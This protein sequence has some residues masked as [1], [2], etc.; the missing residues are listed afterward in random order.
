MVN[1]RI[2]F[3]QTDLANETQMSTQLVPSSC[4]RSG[5][6][7]G[8]RYADYGYPHASSGMICA[9]TLVHIHNELQLRPYSCNED[10]HAIGIDPISLRSISRRFTRF[11]PLAPPTHSM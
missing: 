10:R 1:N 6:R 11:P 4:D 2:V 8:L 5:K 3:Q 9:H 7:V